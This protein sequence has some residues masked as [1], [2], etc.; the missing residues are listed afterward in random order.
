[1][2]KTTNKVQYKG[3]KV[4]FDIES[5]D[6]IEMD[7]TVAEQKD[8]NFHK[9][10]LTEAL[11]KLDLIGNKKTKVAYYLLD[12]MKNDNTIVNTY[13]EIAKGAGVSGETV[14][15]TMKALVDANF[16]KRIRRGYYILNPALVFKGSSQNR[17]Y[18][19]TEYVNVT[20]P[21]NLVK[22]TEEL[23]KE[24]EENIKKMNES[25]IL[26]SDKIEQERE[27]LEVLKSKI[28]ANESDD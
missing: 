1:M 16:I 7:L 14:V 21:Q 26:I 28:A 12:L 18:H 24:S 5:G 17:A 23:I 13:Q 6:A 4:Y 9:V 8:F 10:W 20:K 27:K 22:T 11:Q 15:R 19:V 3:K 25:L 2:K